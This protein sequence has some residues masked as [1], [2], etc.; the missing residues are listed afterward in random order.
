[1]MQGGCLDCKVYMYKSTLEQPFKCWP[2]NGVALEKITQLD[3]E[4][5]LL[6]IPQTTTAQIWSAQ[7][8]CPYGYYYNDNFHSSTFSGK[9][10]GYFFIFN[11]FPKL[12]TMFIFL[13]FLSLKWYLKMNAL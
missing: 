9:V 4:T 11:F 6:T 10:C 2:E 8:I 5:N 7:G 12:A 13:F 3:D 1:M